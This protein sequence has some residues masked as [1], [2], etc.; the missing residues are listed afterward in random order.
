M[1]VLTLVP[2]ACHC[3]PAVCVCEWV[4]L[5]WE[6]LQ[7]V[8]EHVRL[9][10]LL[11]VA[12]CVCAPMKVGLHCFW[13]LGPVLVEEEMLWKWEDNCSIII[14]ITFYSLSC[15]NGSRRLGSIK[16]DNHLPVVHFETGLSSGI[17]LSVSCASFHLIHHTVGW[18]HQ[19]WFLNQN[20]LQ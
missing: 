4:S 5:Y 6:W 15:Y 13:V 20:Y 10:F 2:S 3:R 17:F 7:R 1:G 8:W 19:C 18:K 16:K 9:V 12:I 11:L 14:I